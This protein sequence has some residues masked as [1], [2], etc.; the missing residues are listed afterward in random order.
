MQDEK[1]IGPDDTAPDEMAEPTKP[2]PIESIPPLAKAPKSSSTRA[3][4]PHKPPA[5]KGFHKMRESKAL[6]KVK[7]RSRR[8]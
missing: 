4:K 7:E 6:T 1:I 2:A 5:A 8:G 3:M